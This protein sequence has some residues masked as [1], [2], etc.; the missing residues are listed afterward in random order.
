MELGKNLA[1][2]SFLYLLH[3]RQVRGTITADRVCVVATSLPDT[4]PYFL[5]S[6]LLW[7]RP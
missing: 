7:Q 1:G 5:A 6:V 2:R 3:S 4:Y